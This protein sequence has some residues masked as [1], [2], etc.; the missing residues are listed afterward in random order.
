MWSEKSLE[1]R[2]I[3][4]FETQNQIVK[5]SNYQLERLNNLDIDASLALS[6]M[7][8]L[9]KVEGSANYLDKREKKENTVS[10]SIVY[11][12]TNSRESITQDMRINADFANEICENIGK[13]NGPTHVV[14]SI[15]RGFRGILTFSKTTSDFE[16]NSTVGGDLKV[17]IK[18]LPGIDLSGQAGFSLTENEKLFLESSEVLSL[19]HI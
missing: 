2:K 4:K 1:K 19:I 11:S 13:E 6:F 5:L 16:K 14:T 18:K 3:Q 9:V 7:G 15:T 12:A 8:G 10:A 17:V